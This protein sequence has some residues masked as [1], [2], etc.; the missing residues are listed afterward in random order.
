MSRGIVRLVNGRKSPFNEDFGNLRVLKF[1]IRETKRCLE[2]LAPIVV[3]LDPLD[4]FLVLEFLVL[5]LHLQLLFL[6]N[7]LE[8]ALL[9]LD[10][11]E[12][13]LFFINDA[14]SR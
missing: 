2:E 1:L 13:R 12:E 6:E 9:S 4:S 5:F 10:L 11:V 8:L 7:P 14:D 3:G